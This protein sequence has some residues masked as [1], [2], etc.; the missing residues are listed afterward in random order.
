MPADVEEYQLWVDATTRSPTDVTAP[1]VVGP[2]SLAEALT[3]TGW[4]DPSAQAADVGGGFE[5]NPAEAFT[6]D[7]DS[8]VSTDTADGESHRYSNYD[9]EDALPDDVEIDGIEVRLDW[10][11]DAVDGVNTIDVELSWDGGTTWTAVKSIAVD[12]EPIAEDTDIVGSD[13]DTWGHTWDI[14]DDELADANFRVRVTLQTDVAVRDFSLEWI[15]VRVHY[16][17]S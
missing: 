14:A 4:L 6:D 17:A 15:P 10:L 13:S 12:P 8:A 9:I 5:T 11:L 3:D 16:S 7:G 2:N 1:V